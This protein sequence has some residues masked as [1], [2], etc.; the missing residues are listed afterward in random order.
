MMPEHIPYDECKEET[1]FLTREDMEKKWL[2]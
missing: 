2:S 1:S